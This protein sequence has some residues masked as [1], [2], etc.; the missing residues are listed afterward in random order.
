[1]LEFLCGP[2]ESIMAE[3]TDKT[4]KGYSSL[5]LALRFANG[6]VGSLVGSYD[7]SYA[8]PRT[9]VLEIN[10]SDGRLL[11]E[12]TVQRYAFQ[13]HGNE[14]AEVW[15][16]GYF[17]DRDRAFH[18]TFD[19]YIDALLKA[20]KA[21]NPPPIHAQAGRRALALAYGAIESFE[22]GRR[23]RITGEMPHGTAISKAGSTSQ[24]CRPA[25]GG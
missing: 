6:A 20:F 24:G 7:S 8:Y 2:I 3:M 25:L 10:G 1:M 4:G 17:N 23:V 18:R 12:D 19:K 9:H 5:V 16:A 21:G 11:V 22:T 14:L 13:P 15:Q